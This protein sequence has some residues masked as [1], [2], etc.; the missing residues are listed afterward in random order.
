[1]DYKD[2]LLWIEPGAPAIAIVAGIRR[3]NS[4][5]WRST[6]QQRAQRPAAGEYDM[7]RDGQRISLE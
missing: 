5:H 7:R 2:I 1:M 6:A 3:S 4:V